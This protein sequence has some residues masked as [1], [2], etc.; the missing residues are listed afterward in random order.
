MTRADEWNIYFF[1]REYMCT[2]Y[3]YNVIVRMLR[4]FVHKNTDHG[5]S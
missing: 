5:V 2:V 4:E 1:T 3:H